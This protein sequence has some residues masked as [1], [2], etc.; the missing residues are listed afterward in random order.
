MFTGLEGDALNSLGVDLMNAHIKAVDFDFNN[1]IG[2]PGL[3]SPTQATMYHHEVFQSNGLM[4]GQFG[5]TLFNTSPNLL[6]PI[7]CTGCDHKGAA[8]R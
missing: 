8:I 3:L 4:T 7:W 1:N 2:I 6:R 5:G